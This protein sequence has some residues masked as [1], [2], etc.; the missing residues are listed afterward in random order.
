LSIFKRTIFPS[1]PPG[2]RLQVCF[3]GNR[4]RS[5]FF[6]GNGDTE[7]TLGINTYGINCAD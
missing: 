3:A 1:V 5:S 2:G 4:K 6:G 7:D